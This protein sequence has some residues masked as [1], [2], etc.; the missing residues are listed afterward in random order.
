M[1]CSICGKLATVATWPANG[2]APVY[3]AYQPANVTM[4]TYY[5][6]DH[7][8]YLVRGEYRGE[9]RGFG[10]QAAGGIP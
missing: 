10:Q 4:S 2:A 3:S 6:L 5:C 8:P 9:Y 7:S 1:Y